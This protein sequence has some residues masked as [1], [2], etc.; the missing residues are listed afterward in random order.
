MPIDIGWQHGLHKRLAQ[1]QAHDIQHL[2]AGLLERLEFQLRHAVCVALCAGWPERR[3]YHSL[4]PLTN[5]CAERANSLAWLVTNGCWMQSKRA[6]PWAA[7]NG[8][9]T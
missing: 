4:L 6:Q 2:C 7:Q 5:T 8:Q 3:S 1:T 9:T